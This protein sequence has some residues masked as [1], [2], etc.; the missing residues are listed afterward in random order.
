MAAMHHYIIEIM[1]IY[2]YAATA[3]WEAFVDM[4]TDNNDAVAALERLSWNLQHVDALTQR[5]LAK[6]YQLL[7]WKLP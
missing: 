3:K 4:T 5:L 1:L 6:K 2:T 7:L